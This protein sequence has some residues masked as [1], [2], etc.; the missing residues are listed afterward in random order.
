MAEPLEVHAIGTDAGRK[1]RVQELLEVVGLNPEHFNRFP[2]EF[3]GGQR[4][5]IGVARA[6]A[7]NPKLIVADEPVS[8]L[9]VSSPGADPEPPQ[10]P[11]ERVRADL[12]VHRARPRRRPAHLRSGRRHVPRQA[13][14]AGRCEDLYAAPRHPYTG[15]CCRRFRS[16]TRIGRVAAR[17]PRR[18]RAES[19]RSAERLPLPPPLSAGAG[20]MCRER[21]A[22]RA[23]G[24]EPR[25]GVLL[26]AR[27]VAATDAEMRLESPAAERWARRIPTHRPST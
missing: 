19:D 25:G 6:L 16:R 20:D 7:V 13:R 2:H 15:P 9:D 4:Q 17:S 24:A 8:A 10:G 5:R 18:R 27:E 12:R 14:G 11:A 1:R 22:A 3:S 21:A 26:P 23:A